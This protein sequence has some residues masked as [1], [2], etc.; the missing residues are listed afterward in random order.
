MSQKLAPELEQQAHQFEILLS[1]DFE[2]MNLDELRFINNQF[3]ELMKTVE[4]PSDLYTHEGLDKARDFLWYRIKEEEHKNDQIKIGDCFHTSWGYD[5][6]NIEMYKIVGF[7]KSG[8]SAIIRQI[9]MKTIKGSEGFMSDSVEPD[10]DYEI[11]QKVL[12]EH[13]KLLKDSDQPLPDLK[14]KIERYTDWHPYKN[15]RMQIGEIN[16]R[17]SVYYAGDSKHLQNLYKV[18]PG[19]RTYR[20]W[21]A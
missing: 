17:G 13:T 18:K 9:G 2:H 21:Y 7:T 4:H 11:K 1:N 3:I 19:D 14:V 15:K 6:T 12:D 8:K 16:L 5:Q 10:P 20:S